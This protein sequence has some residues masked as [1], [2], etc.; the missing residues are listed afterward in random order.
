MELFEFY[1][2]QNTWAF[3]KLG[4]A[5]NN[6]C[7]YY[8]TTVVLNTTQEAIFWI[9]INLTQQMRFSKINPKIYSFCK[10]KIRYHRKINKSRSINK[11][12]D[13]KTRLVC[14]CSDWNTKKKP[15]KWPFCPFCAFSFS[16]AETLYKLGRKYTDLFDTFWYSIFK[17]KKSKENNNRSFA[18]LKS[19]NYSKIVSQFSN[20][21]L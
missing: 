18:H 7:W 10:Y 8:N 13:R 5:I 21:T 19:L 12:K 14:L 20:K 2:P 17:K 3:K 15:K 6:P 9:D 16:C 11:W 1:S 4:C